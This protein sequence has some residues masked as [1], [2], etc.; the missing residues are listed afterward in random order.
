MR[1]DPRPPAKGATPAQQSKLPLRML[2]IEDSEEDLE[3]LLAELRDGGYEPS[4]VR[5][6]DENGLREALRRGW[7]PSWTAA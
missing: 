5:V 3:L 2:V 6:E 4:F 1:Q 7:C